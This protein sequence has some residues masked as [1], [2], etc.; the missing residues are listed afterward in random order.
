VLRVD[1]AVNFLSEAT[2]ISELRKIAIRDDG[3]VLSG[4]L[5]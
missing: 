5:R 2:D 4:A 1:G 3:S